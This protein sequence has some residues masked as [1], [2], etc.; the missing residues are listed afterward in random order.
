METVLKEGETGVFRSAVTETV[1]ERDGVSR[2]VGAKQET[3]NPDQLTKRTHEDIKRY[4]TKDEWEELQDWEKEVYRDIK[5]HYD[6]IV[7]FGYNVPKPDFMSEVEETHQSPVCL[8]T[9]FKEEES[10]LP[11]N[12]LFLDASES[13]WSP[14]SSIHPISNTV[15]VEQ[16][17]RNQKKKKKRQRPEQ[18]FMET[19]TVQKKTP[20]FYDCSECGKS[21]RLAVHLH[22]HQ[23]IHKG[24]EQNKCRMSL[25]DLPVRIIHQQIQ[26]RKKLNTES[27]KSLRTSS[28]FNNH[29]QIQREKPY[30]N[31]VC[32]KS[33][34]NA[35]DCSKHQR[36]QSGNKRYKCVECGKSFKRS[37]YLI[38]HQQIHTGE[39]PYNCFECGKS[40]RLSTGLKR[41]QQIHTGEKPYKCTECG[42]SFRN[43]SNLIRHQRVHT[44]EKPYKCTECGKSFSHSSNLKIHQ[45]IHTGE[46][47]YKCT[48]CE[49]SF[50]HSSGLTK[51]LQSPSHRR[52]TT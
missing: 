21:F 14:S 26:T 10:L 23:D 7:S 52:E 9:H 16:S 27:R 18:N 49:K 43:S 25:R 39:K 35:S 5:E 6:V 51:H 24:K 15:S 28:D 38:T 22:K 1:R 19:S 46:K 44:G 41:H 36:I 12:K 8:S 48:E 40:F 37:A 42:K 20:T 3:L 29:L 17:E 47:P 50:R 34:R 13:A 31:T 33:F 32:G 2:L 4:F 11:E 30:N 45:G